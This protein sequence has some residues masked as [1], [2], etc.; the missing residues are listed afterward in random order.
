M[1][2]IFQNPDTYGIFYFDIF[3]RK[4][5][6]TTVK[7]MIHAGLFFDEIFMIFRKF[8]LYSRQIQ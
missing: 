2:H 8:L 7:G 5:G 3:I 4:S 1:N 6:G